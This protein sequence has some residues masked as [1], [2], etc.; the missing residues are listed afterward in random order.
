M[1]ITSVTDGQYRI[2]SKILQKDKI[3]HDDFIYTKN[4]LFKHRMKNK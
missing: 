3:T 4:L 1:K 2:C